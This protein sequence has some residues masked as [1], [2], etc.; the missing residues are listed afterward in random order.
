M[1]TIKKGL[2]LPITGEPSKEI[3]EHTPT[4]VALIGYDYIGMRPTM[5]VK[6]GD[7]VAKGQVL[8]EDKK[9]LGVKYTAPI[10][11][12]VIAVNRGERRV[13][14]SLVIEAQKGDE[15]TFKVYDKSAGRVINVQGLKVTFQNDDTQGTPANPKILDITQNF[16]PGD[17][18][19]DGEVTMDDV[20]M[21]I[22]ASLGNVPAKYNM[23][24]GDVDGDGEITINDVVIIINM[25]Q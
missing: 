15:I 1:I 16:N 14:E 4:H 12:K 17:V 6:E 23:A 19:D 20:L 10:S 13:F 7:T 24:A 21:T 11:G 5:H 25:K 2:D 8:F 9:R 18:N 3:S 22:D